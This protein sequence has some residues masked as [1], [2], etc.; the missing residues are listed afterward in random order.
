MRK[1]RFVTLATVAIFG[2]GASPLAPAAMPVID[3]A[4]LIQTTQTA[5]QA[6]KTEVYQNTNVAYQYKMMANQL[7]QATGLNA[8]AVQAQ[9][10]A[11]QADADKLTS[12]RQANESLY[13]SLGDAGSYLQRVQSLIVQSG[14]TPAQWFSD[15][16]TLVANGDTSAKQ[17]YSLGSDIMESNRRLAQRRQQIH[18]TLHLSP[19]AEA[20]AQ[21]TNQLLDVI[22]SQNTQ[23][24]QL[25]SAKAQAD[26]SSSQQ[27]VSQKQEAL[28]A[29]QSLEAA[30]ESQRQQLGAVLSTSSTSK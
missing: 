8:G 25:M 27:G 28:A 12:Y 22:A 5:L 4:N 9:A 6:V 18:D 10:A 21:S 17:L 13:G 19:T 16:Q 11:I 2:A 29:Q 15:Q 3:V 7:L 24:L 20:T 14:K 26:A 1:S 30:R 23:L